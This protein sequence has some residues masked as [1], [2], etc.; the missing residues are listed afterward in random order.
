MFPLRRQRQRCLRRPRAAVNLTDMENTQP[1]DRMV[2]FRM[3]QWLGRPRSRRSLAPILFGVG[4]ALGSTRSAR[5]AC[6]TTGARCDPVGPIPCCSGDCAKRHGKRA[7]APAGAAFGCT[8]SKATDFC[9]GG[10]IISVHCPAHPDGVCIVAREK[11]PFCASSFE[12]FP[13]RHDAD[14]AAAFTAPTA[15]CVTRCA[16]CSD[17]GLTSVCALPIPAS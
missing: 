12:C 6:L 16:I 9:H 7:C 3:L 2:A 10:D 17:V 13:C 1:M 15:R 11:H 5:A 8:K 14:C 4:A